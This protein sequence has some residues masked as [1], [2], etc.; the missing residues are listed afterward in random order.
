M[1]RRGDD[2][3][4]ITLV[5]FGGGCDGSYVIR[6]DVRGV[7]RRPGRAASPWS[8][9]APGSGSVNTPCVSA[10]A[11]R[12]DERVVPAAS[13]RYATYSSA[14]GTA[15]QPKTTLDVPTVSPSEGV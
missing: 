1:F 12:H 15:P 6:T 7:V 14:S 11:P 4:C 13:T 10:A 9:N 3:P 8:S 5:G 2:N